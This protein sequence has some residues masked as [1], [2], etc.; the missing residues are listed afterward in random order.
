VIFACVI[1]LRRK[2]TAAK[3]SPIEE[4]FYQ[5]SSMGCYLQK[6]SPVAGTG[7]LVVPFLKKT[8]GR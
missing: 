7:G 2:L 5:S 8:T 6:A 1:E 4:L 3:K